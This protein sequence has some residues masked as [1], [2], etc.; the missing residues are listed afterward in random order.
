MGKKK[1]MYGKEKELKI[2]LIVVLMEA[3]TKL[4]SIWYELLLNL[5]AVFEVIMSSQKRTSI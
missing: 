4:I 2:Q 1:R 3:Q 5:M